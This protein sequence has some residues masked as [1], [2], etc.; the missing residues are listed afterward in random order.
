M[1]EAISGAEETDEHNDLFCRFRKKK[2]REVG[3]ILALA[4]NLK[5]LSRLRCMNQLVMEVM[6]IRVN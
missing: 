3:I 2:H 1:V 4:W 5:V 6:P